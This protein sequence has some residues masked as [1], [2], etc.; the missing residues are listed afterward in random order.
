MRPLTLAMR[1]LRHHRRTNLAV[2]LGVAAGASALTGALLVGDSMRGSLRDAVL[3]RLGRVDCAIVASGFFRQGLAGDL[4]D[5]PGLRDAE[6]EPAPVI[7]LRGSAVHA[8]SRAR[9]N[10]V[11]VLGVESRFWRMGGVAPDPLRDHVDGRSIVVNETL[12][13]AL[14][15]GVGDDVLLNLPKQTGISTDMLLGRRDDAT[16][17]LRMTIRAVVPDAGIGGFSPTP[18][19][20]VAASAFVPLQRLAEAVGQPGRANL[21][22]CAVAAGDSSGVS[23]RPALDVALR[24]RYRLDDAGLSLRRDSRHGY[25]ALESRDFLIKP[26]IEEAAI[27]AAAVTGLPPLRILTHLANSI[28]AVTDDAQAATMPESHRAN[29]TTRAAQR[30][31]PYSTLS[32]IEDR[33]HAAGETAAFL[34]PPAPGEMILNDW[35]ATDLGVS[36]GDPLEIEYYVSGPAGELLTRRATFRVGGVISLEGPAS[37]P[38][39]TPAYQGITDSDRLADWDPPFPVDL[40]RVRPRD[41]DYWRQYR[42]TPKAFVSLSDGQRLWAE[43]GDRFG[44]ITSI[45]LY[46]PEP[47]Q[48]EPAA[49]QFESALRDRLRPESAGLLIRPLRGEALSAAAGNVD[50]GMLFVSF[51]AFLIAAAAMLVGLLMRLAVERRSGE[52]GI[53]LATGFTPADVRR[54]L[55]V[56][57]AALAAI[58]AAIGLAGAAAYS[59]LMLAGLRSWWASAVGAPFLSLHA[60]A[61]SLL[62]GLSASFAIALGAILWGLRGLLRFSPRA[63]LA[64]MVATGSPAAPAARRRRSRHVCIAAVV[65]AAILLGLST[66]TDAVP[67]AVGF[68]AVGALLLVAALAFGDSVLWRPARLPIR[69]QAWRGIAR[70]GARHVTRDPARGLT[71]MALIGAATFLVVSMDAFRLDPDDAGTDRGGAAGGF[72]WIAEAA[73]NLPHDLGTPSGR[74]AL[75]LPGE[76]RERLEHAEVFS[77]RL[78]PGGDASCLGLYR[79]ERP[80]ILGAPAAMIER[81]GF[82]FAG[83]LAETDLERAN[84]WRLLNR[85]M[86]EGAIPVIGDEAAVRWQLHRDLGED[87]VIQDERG[88]AARLRFVALLSGSTLQGELIVSEADFAR[89][90][91]SVGGYGFFL[92]G[93]PRAADVPGAAGEGERGNWNAAGLASEL[94]SRLDRFGLDVTPAADRL[95]GYLAVQNTYLST[96]QSLGGFGLALGVAGLAAVMLRNVWERRAELALLRAVGYSR[97]ALILLVLSEN[98]VLVVGGLLAGL[99]PAL[100]AVAPQIAARP[101][102][103][104]WASLIAL[105]LGILLTGLIAGIAALRP[106][107]RAPLVPAL[108]A[109]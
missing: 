94:E 50:F 109:E 4:R 71:T 21:L 79:A 68:F 55:L 66:G 37:D 16:I 22:L 61:S 77:F 7:L 14:G 95:R 64:G 67:P 90:F 57:G 73:V 15:A 84:P 38:G 108:R 32:A 29:A 63:L 76:L 60:S 47:S 49:R 3:E 69:P 8:G 41:E 40:K 81:G 19:Q 54:L 65:S 2:V 101:A 105:P 102:S 45:R 39:F 42:A 107:L 25:I 62:I 1:S 99:L 18:S 26:P 82:R 78:Q 70:L 36:P 30:A 103:I 86:T 98:A 104:R 34:V 100:V 11:Q 23:M 51:S 31:I 89:L 9:S 13:S 17:L 83:S 93:A 48:M 27:G 87:L 53:L 20:S 59:W 85:C 43:Q 74:A 44:R 33:P 28:A 5:A 96:F 52:V 6:S 46:P 12:A 106:T 75:D 72:A 88:R 92:I 80:R 24:T 58:G 10:R 91:P 35:A 97:R 56:E